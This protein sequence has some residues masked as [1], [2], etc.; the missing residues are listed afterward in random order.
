MQTFLISNDFAQCARVLDSQRLS[1][2]ITETCQLAKILHCYGLVIKEMNNV[3]VGIS[4]PQAIKLWVD[5]KGRICFPELYKYGSAMNNEWM[6][7]NNG[8]QHGSWVTFSWVRTGHLDR[9]A[10]TL[11]WPVTV[12]ESHISNLLRKDYSYYSRQLSREL[13]DVSC[14][15]PM[16]YSWENPS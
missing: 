6:K 13:I 1:R 16:E 7:R 4:F 15:P 2:Q 10:V 3:P 12:Y 14:I 11:Q 9:P 5:V 8:T